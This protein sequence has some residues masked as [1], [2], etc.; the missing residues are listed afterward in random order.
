MFFPSHLVPPAYF[1]SFGALIRGIQRAQHLDA[2]PVVCFFV[3]SISHMLHVWN[4]YTYIWVMFEV[5]VGKYSIHGAYGFYN[6][7]C[8]PGDFH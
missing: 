8:A 4:I 6:Y 1:H 5:N 7:Q 3:H 2:H